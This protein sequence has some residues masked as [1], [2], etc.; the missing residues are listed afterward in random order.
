MRR[1]N[2]RFLLLS[3]LA[4]ALVGTILGRSLLADLRVDVPEYQ[5]PP[6]LVRLDQNW[7]PEQRNAFH[8]TPQGTRL[9]P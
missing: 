1:L 9:L 2:R 3:L 8:F 5:R 6:E 7:T 4:L